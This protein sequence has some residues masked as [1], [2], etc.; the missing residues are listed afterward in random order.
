MTSVV[1]SQQDLERD[2]VFMLSGIYE[3]WSRTY[4][5]EKYSIDHIIDTGSWKIPKILH[6]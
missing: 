5:R 6:R 2:L 1:R 4:F 3:A